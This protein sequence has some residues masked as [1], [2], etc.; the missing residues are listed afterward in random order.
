MRHA[1]NGM[2]YV[3]LGYL[4][5]S[6]SNSS[7]KLLQVPWGRY[8]TEPQSRPTYVCSIDN[9]SAER[10]HISATTLIKVL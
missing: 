2:V 1:L 3:S 8:S 5:P 6:Y 7:A 4:I 9:K 10:G